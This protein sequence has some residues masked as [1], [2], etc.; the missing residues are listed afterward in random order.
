MRGQNQ[1]GYRYYRDPDHDYGGNCPGNR[2]HINADSIEQCAADYLMSVKLPEEWKAQIR[3]Q[4]VGA[5]GPDDMRRRKVRAEAKIRRAKELYLEQAL[6]RAQY[7]RNVREAQVE[8][9]AL[10]P[11]PQPNLE[12]VGDLLNDLPRLWTLATLEERK[13]LF[14]AMLE[15][16][17]VRGGDVIALQPR[18]EFY[19]LLQFVSGGPDEHRV[20]RYTLLRPGTPPKEALLLIEHGLGTP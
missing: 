1:K 5:K 16:V 7:D 10:K 9:D 14:Q 13:T 20:L 17:Y 3:A 12:H 8:I 11:V 6:T 4:S 2:T 15:R 18:A 19:P